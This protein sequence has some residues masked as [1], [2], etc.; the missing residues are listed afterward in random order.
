MRLRHTFNNPIT[1]CALFLI[2]MTACQEGYEEIIIPPDSQLIESNDELAGVITQITMLDGSADNV[3]D[4]V[5]CAQVL[6]PVQIERDDQIMTIA[7]N[8]DIQ[9][10]LLDSIEFELIFP[11]RV[12]MYDH[13]ILVLDDDDELE[14]IQDACAENGQDPDIECIDFIYPI[15]ISSFDL[16]SEIAS[17]KVLQNDQETY[18]YFNALDNQIVSLEYPI[19]LTSRDGTSMIA[20]DQKELISYLDANTDCDEYDTIPEVDYFKNYQIYRLLTS[21]NWKIREFIMEEDNLTAD[22]QD[23]V[24]SFENEWVIR[25]SLNST[26]VSGEW[27]LELDEENPLI[28][29][30]FDSEEELWT[31]L[32]ETWIIQQS[33]EQFIRL[34]N[35]DEAASLELY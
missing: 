9:A 13:S 22:Y 21:R 23:V 25:G 11:I 8:D 16:I 28:E 19:S 2:L 29:I 12:R 31:I 10:L 26:I 33:T 34:V 27:E 35:E 17:V 20:Q 15:T 5:S 7:N 32:N 1:V 24:I 14:E 3:L 30:D 6:L 4:Q 18:K